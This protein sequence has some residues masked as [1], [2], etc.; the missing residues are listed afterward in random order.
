[1]QFMEYF[2]QELKCLQVPWL[3]NGAEPTVIVQ[4]TSQQKAQNE[5][6]G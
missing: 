4:I 5:F 1:M 6:P 2:S 3:Y